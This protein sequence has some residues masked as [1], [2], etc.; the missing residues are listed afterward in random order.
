MRVVYP[1]TAAQ[2]FHALRRQIASKV[3]VP[4][5][6]FTPKKYLRAP[7]V[8]SSVEDLASGS[9]HPVLDD[10]NPPA[11]KRRVLLCSGKI[12]HEIIAERDARKAPAVVIRLEELYPFPA[13]ELAAVLANYPPNTELFWVQEE[14]QNMGPWNFV[15][16]EIIDNLRRP[17]TV[18][19]RA[20][21]ASPATGSASV[22][23]VEHRQ[24][25]DRALAGLV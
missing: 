3:R 15:R 6:C 24:L 20:R 16:G 2:Y 5:I 9:F 1:T 22:H 23:E 17:V 21:S 14:P 4:L 7:Q 25:L 8:R 18:A 11:M 10:P 13:A 19:A 12:A